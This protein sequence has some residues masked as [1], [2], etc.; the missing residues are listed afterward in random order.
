MDQSPFWDAKRFQASQE[1]PYILLYPKVHYRVHN[2]PPP[3]PIL[4]QI[5]P[6][7]AHISL[8]EDPF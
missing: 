2:S 1:I 4:R 6:V 8:L 3:I 7:Q 5:S